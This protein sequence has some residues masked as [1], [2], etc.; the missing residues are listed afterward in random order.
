MEGIKKQ[1]DLLLYR[2]F[3]GK[4]NFGDLLV[5]YMIQKIPHSFCAMQRVGLELV[6]KLSSTK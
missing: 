2:R 5:V 6:L 1:V 3:S 4:A